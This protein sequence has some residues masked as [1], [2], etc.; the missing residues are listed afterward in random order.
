[1][2]QR[3]ITAM[4]HVVLAGLCSL[5]PFAAMA[6]TGDINIAVI[7]HASRNDPGQ[8]REVLGATDYERVAFIL[9]NGIKQASE[10]CHDELYLQRKALLDNARSSVVVSL[11]ASDWT[12][13]LNGQNNPAAVERLNRLREVFFNE[14][15]A[16]ERNRLQKLHQSDSAKFHNFI[17]NARWQIHGIQFATV[18]LPADNNHYLSEAGRNSEFEDRLIATNDWLQRIVSTASRNKSP[19]IVLFSDGNPMA[20]AAPE[21]LFGSPSRRDGF[22]EVRRKITALAATYKGKILIV[23]GQAGDAAAKPATIVWQKNI[24][25]LAAGQ[26]SA[27]AWMKLTVNPAAANPFRVTNEA[28]TAAGDKERGKS[29]SN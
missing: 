2:T 8:L 7:A 6:K 21:P 13:C 25:S 22:R 23:H 16:P 24:G 4:L 17:E 19:L 14:E 15:A 28:V 27:S 18:N 9:V 11:A 1:M 3:A 5:Q 29:A 10:S 26:G 20:A 12:T